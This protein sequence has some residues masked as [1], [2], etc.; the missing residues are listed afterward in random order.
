MDGLWDVPGKKLRYLSFYPLFRGSNGCV[1]SMLRGTCPISMIQTL[2]PPAPEKSGYP[3]P[4]FPLFRG[5]RA[6]AAALGRIRW[7]R[8][9]SNSVFLREFLIQ[10]AGFESVELTKHDVNDLCMD[11]T[12][13]K[14]LLCDFTGRELMPR[15]MY[16]FGNIWQGLSSNVPCRQK[17]SACNS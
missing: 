12:E 2:E 1:H 7:R 10:I 16:W 5:G 8:F 6:C 4:F 17:N 3:D 11:L 13:V 15:L 14:M 9:S